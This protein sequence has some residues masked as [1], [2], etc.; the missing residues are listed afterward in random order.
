MEKNKLFLHTSTLNKTMH[1]LLNIFEKNKEWADISNWLVKVVTVL[2]KH[3]S[4]YIT[5]K[6]QLSKRLAQCLNPVLPHGVHASAI[7]IYFALFNN[8]R[9]VAG[10]FNVE[11]R[12][13][14][15]EDQ[16]LYSFGMFAFYANASNQVKRQIL[17][18]VR[19]FYL[20]IGRDLIP[21]LPGL[22]L[23]L[24]TGIEENNQEVLKDLHKTLD[25]LEETA[26]RRYFLGAFW[27]ALIRNKR[28]RAAQIKY[29]AKKIPKIL[30]HD[31]DDDFS[32]DDLIAVSISCALNP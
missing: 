2:K 24:V 27:L 17:E 31:E 25:K 1:H 20:P 18:I 12:T 7:K 3:P 5:E 28:G 21:A 9:Q 15:C 10:G 23:A 32:E 8:M 22:V 19:I 26:G 4:P 13:M 30:T 11:Y 16:G 14:F 6:I 29:L